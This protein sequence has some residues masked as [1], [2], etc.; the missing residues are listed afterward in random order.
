[1]ATATRPRNKNVVLRMILSNLLYGNAVTIVPGKAGTIGYLR[2]KLWVCAGTPSGA[3][4]SGMAAKDIILDTT[5]SK[6]YRYITGTT[7]VDIT[8]TS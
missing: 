4:P 8:A 1:M 3:I 6:V 2:S 7:Y 5:N